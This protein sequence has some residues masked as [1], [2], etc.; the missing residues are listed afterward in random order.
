MA[1]AGSGAANRGPARQGP[2]P[3]RATDGARSESGRS[4]PGGTVPPRLAMRLDASEVRFGLPPWRPPDVTITV[5]VPVPVT[6]VPGQSCLGGTVQINQECKSCARA[7]S[8]RQSPKRQWQSPSAT[9]M[10]A[11]TSVAS[12]RGKRRKG[13]EEDDAGMWS[14]KELKEVERSKSPV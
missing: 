9:R 14:W 4:R 13:R 3:G 12:S 10:M 8:R 5:A 1:A 7:G 2:L 11:P 6:V